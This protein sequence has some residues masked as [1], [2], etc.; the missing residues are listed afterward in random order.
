LIITISGRPGSGKST[1]AKV[2]AARLGFDH[3]SAGDFMREMATERG[4]TVLELSRDAE[5]DPGVDLEIDMRTARLGRER[6]GFVMDSRLAWFFI[7]HSLKVFL[8]VAIEE[9]A[10]RIFGA[11]RAGEI[12]NTDLESTMRS[13]LARQTSESTRYLTYYGIDYQDPAH[14]DLVVDTTGMG[15]DEVVD[16]IVEHLEGVAR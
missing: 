7:P 1:V 13:T 11:Q 8:D 12:E 10:H 6:A 2:L 9:A 4:K 3:F 16:D 14:Y 15:V 5:S